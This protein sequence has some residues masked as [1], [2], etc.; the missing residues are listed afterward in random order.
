MCTNPKHLFR[1]T[2]MEVV[3]LQEGD[4]F[5]M[6]KDCFHFRVKE[7]VVV[8]VKEVTVEDAEKVED[9]G[10]KVKEDID[11]KENTETQDHNFVKPT[12]TGLSAVKNKRKLPDWMR[13]KSES[14]KKAKTPMKT[15]TNKTNE[16]Y[17]ANVN[18]VTGGGEPSRMKEVDNFEEIKEND[19]VVPNSICT[20]IDDSDNKPNEN[21]E[22]KSVST[23]DDS[24]IVEPK[25]HEVPSPEL[26]KEEIIFPVLVTKDDLEDNDGEDD[27]MKTS[28][29]VKETRPQKP[30]RKSCL[31]GSSCYRS[32][33]AHRQE[34]AHPGDEDFREQQDDEDRDDDR[35]E[36]EYGSECY[37][38][39]PQ[40]R[41][42]FK[43]SIRPL[44]KRKAK[45]GKKKTGGAAGDADDYESDFIDDEEDGWE[46]VDDSD[47]DKDY[48]PEPS[49]ELESQD[50]L[51]TE[52]AEDD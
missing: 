31:Y 32:N 45:E 34:E 30:L 7:I 29:A 26:E 41:K 36:C 22:V 25:F 12:S 52:D 24:N 47:D 23:D 27:K 18:F 35:P 48:N 28:P 13:D 46:P 42:D 43:H 4:E 33:P 10:E 20:D 44:P 49:S 38:K 37:R 5:M 50:L 39:N 1:N 16:R 51:D 3:K 15:T 40:H 14:P 2:E 9:N 21:P 17:L 8:G 11:S 6:V 19:A